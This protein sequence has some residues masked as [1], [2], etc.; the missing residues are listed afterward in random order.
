MTD[1]RPRRT[2]IKNSFRRGLFHP[3]DIKTVGLMPPSPGPKTAPLPDLTHKRSRPSLNTLGPT[4]G[5][6]TPHHARSSSSSYAGPSSGSF[7]RSEARRLHSQPEFGK[8]AEDD[9][10]DYDDVFGKPANG[11]GM[12][13]TGLYGRNAD[14]CMYSS[15]FDGNSPVEHKTVQQVMG[16]SRIVPFN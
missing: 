3:D 9:D 2:Q 10:E 7:G 5:T 1:E 11:T 15:T 12:L 16:M 6:T 8:Y 13:L 14:K 4:S